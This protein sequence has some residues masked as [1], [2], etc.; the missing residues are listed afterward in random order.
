MQS[1]SWAV[2]LF[3]FHLSFFSP[4]DL[5]R[6]SSARKQPQF[7]LQHCLY[8]AS[9]FTSQPLV[10]LLSYC[11]I[12]SHGHRDFLVLFFGLGDAG[13]SHAAGCR[14][15]LPSLRWPSKDLLLACSWLS[16]PLVILQFSP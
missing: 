15:I 5:V 12:L 10:R 3:L 9:A 16:S 6:W 13:N 14:L 4:S 2:S 1:I 8:S 7:L 11:S